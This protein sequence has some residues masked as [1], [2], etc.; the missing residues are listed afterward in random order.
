MSACI[1]QVR[2]HEREQAS[3]RERERERERRVVNICRALQ[4]GMPA[5]LGGACRQ[6]AM[7]NSSSSEA[8]HIMGF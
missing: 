8:E 4:S 5:G 2:V 7:Q 6:I 1:V 3:E